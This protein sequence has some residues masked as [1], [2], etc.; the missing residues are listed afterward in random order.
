VLGDSTTHNVLD[1]PTSTINHINVPNAG[2][3]TNLMEAFSHFRFLPLRCRHE[4]SHHRVSLSISTGV[5]KNNF[6]LTLLIFHFVLRVSR[7]LLSN[8]LRE[9]KKL[10]YH[11]SHWAF[12][13]ATYASE[14]SK[15]LCGANSKYA[16]SSNRVCLNYSF[17]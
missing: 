15:I 13:F 14:R 6:L 3:W 16:V 11:I 5:T 12:D 8:N 4:A 1:T 9:L 7:G 17:C 10:V 2:L